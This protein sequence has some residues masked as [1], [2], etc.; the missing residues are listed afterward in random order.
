MH[1]LILLRNGESIWNQ[2]NRFTGWTDVD[3]SEQGKGEAKEAGLRL[4]ETGIVFDLVFT[5][6]LKRAIRTAWI[7]ADVLDRMWIP[8]RRDWRL[9]ERHYGAL[10]GLNKSETAE[11]Y[12]AEQVHLWRRSYAIRPPALTEDDPRHPRHD[13][14]Y[15]SLPQDQLPATE[16]LEDT[17]KRFWKSWQEEIEPAVLS[18]RHVLIAAHNNSL[19]ALV[20][21]LDGISDAEIVSLDIPTGIPL[22]YE[23]DEHLHPIR[24]QYLAR[25]PG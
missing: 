22:V 14:R 3:L 8:I 9:N 16:S 13:P 15:A 5:S 25:A 12:G 21:H 20:K 7:V 11:K 17:E 4:K 6:F 19:R 23:L 24:H 18:G 2:E 10:Q 1:R